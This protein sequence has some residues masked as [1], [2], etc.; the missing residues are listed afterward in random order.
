MT[1][2]VV[3]PT[4]GNR[5][6][7]P[8]LLSLKNSSIK[9]DEIIISAPTQNKLDKNELQKIKN[10]RIHISK[11]RGQVIQRIEGFKITNCDIVVQLDDDIILEKYC[12]ELLYEEIK[13][14]SD[15]SISPNL[16][17]SVSNRSIYLEKKGLKKYLFN[18]IMGFNSDEKRGKIGLGGFQYYPVLNFNSNILLD[19]EWLVGGCVMHHKK[20]LIL[21]NYFS[22]NGKA[23]CEDLFHSIE[24]KKRGVKLSLL[25]SATAFLKLTTKTPDIIPFFKE[26]KSDYLIRKELVKQNGLNYNRMLIGYLFIIMNFFFKS[27]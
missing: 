2:S 12:L 23:Y 1:I 7:F 10:V 24:L 8:T 26:L 21:S 17:D 27:K 18:K 11:F 13:N 22:F 3:I 4:I 25:S 5:N 6:L 14:K 19:S 15:T 20:N 16:I 9:I